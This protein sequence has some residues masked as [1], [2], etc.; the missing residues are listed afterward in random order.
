MW[1]YCHRV[2]SEIPFNFEKTSK[3]T[4]SDKLSKYCLCFTCLFVL[5]HNTTYSPWMTTGSRTGG[6]QQ[7]SGSVGKILIIL[8]NL[9]G[10]QL[11]PRECIK[12]FVKLCRLYWPFLRKCGIYYAQEKSEKFPTVIYRQVDL[13]LRSSKQQHQ[14]PW[15]T[16]WKFKF[17]GSILYWIRNYRGGA[18]KSVFDKLSRWFWCLL[19]FENHC[20]RQL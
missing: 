12:M 8:Q 11:L 15:R 4:V 5:C 9:P 17:F 19:K 3:E 7:R 6:W 1:L 16:G 14:L 10:I 20:Y 18:Q 13:K 2:V